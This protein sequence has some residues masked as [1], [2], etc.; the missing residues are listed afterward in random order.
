MFLFLMTGK[1]T[2][3]ALFPSLQLEKQNKA[4]LFYSLQTAEEKHNRVLFF[5]G[6]DKFF[7]FV[8]SGVMILS[9]DI[10]TTSEE[11]P[12]KRV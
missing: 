4:V 7:N 2:N 5:L 1:C 11:Q 9:K 3:S 8:D 10:P 12:A 6:K